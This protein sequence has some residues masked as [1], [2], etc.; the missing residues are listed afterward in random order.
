M[1]EIVKY[2]R[3]KAAKEGSRQNV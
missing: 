1:N 3:C 2:R